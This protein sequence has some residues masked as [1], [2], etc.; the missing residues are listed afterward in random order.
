MEMQQKVDAQNRQ[1]TKNRI[2]VTTLS[3]NTNIVQNAI[4]IK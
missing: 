3:I 2:I 4:I 1:I